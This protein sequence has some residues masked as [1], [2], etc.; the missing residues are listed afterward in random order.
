MAG[1]R[2]RRYSDAVC[3][4]ACE[5]VALAFFLRASTLLG[6]VNFSHLG[7]W[8]QSTS[9]ELALTSMFRLLG[10]A[11][12]GWLLLSTLLYAAAALSGKRSAIAKSRLITLPA[13]RRVI[14]S[15]VVASVAASSIGSAAAVSG[16]TPASHITTIARPIEPAR[17][18]TKPARP[19]EGNSQ[20]AGA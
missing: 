7:K 4:L 19:T 8:L 18:G 5:M 2:V 3:V 12:S 6:T 14:D 16:A 13:L 9:P 10:L 17:P 11:I 20:R 15:V 1:N